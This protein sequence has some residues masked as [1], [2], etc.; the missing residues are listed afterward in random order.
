MIGQV[1][2][3]RERFG[4]YPE[5][6]LG[7]QIYGTREN[8]K[9]LK[10]K[11]IRYSGKALGRPRKLSKEEKRLLSEEG[12]QKYDLNLVKA[13]TKETS[14]SWIA[15]VFFVMNIAHWM[16]LCFFAQFSR[17]VFGKII[18]NLKEFLN[19]NTQYAPSFSR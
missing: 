4:Y 9:Y 1:E 3:Y 5:A 2:S 14:E 8:R 11:G 18:R 12:K 19:R 6:V 13:K 7:D 17:R 15:A 10:A 16:R